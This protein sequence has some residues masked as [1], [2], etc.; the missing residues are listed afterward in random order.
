M[1][2][3]AAMLVAAWLWCV[4]SPTYAVGGIAELPALA[5]PSGTSGLGGATYA[6]LAGAAAGA[7]VIAAGAWYARR[8]LVR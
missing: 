8:R 7:V 1:P 4:T 6:V 2:V 5:G 3:L